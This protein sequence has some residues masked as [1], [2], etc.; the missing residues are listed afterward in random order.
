MPKPDGSARAPL[1]QIIPPLHQPPG[2]SVA[3]LDQGT[4][5]SVV[6]LRCAEGLRVSH[7]SATRCLVKL[8]PA[9]RYL[10]MATSHWKAL[11]AFGDGPGRSVPQVLF[12]LIMDRDCVQL[13]EFYEIVIKAYQRGIL[14]TEGAELP[15]PIRPS[16]WAHVMPAPWARLAAIAGG[17]LAVAALFR[18]PLALPSNLPELLAGWV[19]VCVALSVG[20]WLAAG[21]VRGADSE[22]YAPGFLWRSPFPRFRA[23]LGDAIMSGP[24]AVADVALAQLAPVMVALGA[25]AL[26]L[27]GAAL[28]PAAALATLL[29][30]FWWSP[31]I[32]ILHAGTGRGRED[33]KWD[34]QFEPNREVWRAFTTRLRHLDLRFIGGHVAYSLLWIS[35]LLGLSGL[36]LYGN[37]TELW[38]AFHASGGP[39]ITAFIVFALLLLAITTAISALGAVGFLAWRDHLAQRPRPRG[40]PTRDGL[41]PAAIAACVGESLLFQMLP[42]ADRALIAASFEPERHPAG[43]VIIREGEAG[44]KLYLLHS[45][46]VEVTRLLPNGREDAVA[47]LKPGDV[48]GEIALLDG[49]PRT[50]SVRATRPSV[51]LALSREAFAGMVLPRLSRAQIEETVQKIAFLQRT[52]LAMNWSPHALAAFARRAAFQ[53]YPADAL[54]LQEGEDNHF[55]Y[56]VHEGRLIVQRGREE[57]AQ[58]GV[59]DFF[60]EISLLQN[61]ITK[62]TIVTRTPA[63]FL[64]MH[65]R[66]F[67]QFFAKDSSIGLQFE[68]I[69]SERLG[70]AI[71]PLKGK[72]LDLLKA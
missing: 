2:F 14:R 3:A 54:V 25:C 8:E 66:D 61:S 7:V 53:D 38:R 18:H 29:A 32:R 45:G 69:S 70:E 50:R 72:S 22:V 59:G 48:F 6:E 17:A 31:G 20:N 62:A 9:R 16:D 11:R 46:S 44:D 5:L 49:S 13:R 43:S 4:L 56:L 51:V 23:D 71:F 12:Q 26:V 47:S 40:Q 60:G 35:A 19:V 34:F 57:V 10:S 1:P 63:R 55:F 41:D 28:L 65:K 39:R 42:E 37:W 33:D 30:P 68:A 24:R 64:V 52:T 58:L 27:P 15:P 36:L 67:L 21:V